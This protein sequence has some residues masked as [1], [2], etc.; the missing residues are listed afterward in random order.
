ML[1][2]KCLGG[3]W[4]IRGRIK[5][6]KK[7]EKNGKIFKKVLTNKFHDVNMMKRL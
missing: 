2:I 7:I 1:S 4:S 6:G 5:K 3:I